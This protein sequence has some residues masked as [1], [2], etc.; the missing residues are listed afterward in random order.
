[1]SKS[2]NVF[3]MNTTYTIR[4]QLDNPTLARLIGEQCEATKG[5]TCVINQDTAHTAD[6][7]ITDG[8]VVPASDIPTISIPK[9]TIR[10]GE[11]LDRMRYAVSGREIHIEDEL[12]HLDLGAFIL[13]PAENILLHKSDNQEIRLTDKERLVLRFLYEAGEVGLARNALL[14]DVWGYADDAETHTLETHIYRLRQKLEPFAQQNF[15]KVIDGVYIL[16]TKKP[17]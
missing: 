11:I 7:I 8:T 5:L 15:I 1:M 10:L 14:K 12:S 3:S 6:C 17:A 2:A 4:L 16:D 13:R 9:G